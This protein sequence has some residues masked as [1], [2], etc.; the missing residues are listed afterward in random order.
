[1]GILIL[2]ANATDAMTTLILESGRAGISARGHMAHR[3]E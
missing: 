1:L 2:D 3:D